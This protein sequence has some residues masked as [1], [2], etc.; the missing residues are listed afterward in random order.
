MDRKSR[1]QK[2]FFKLLATEGTGSDA[3][4]KGKIYVVHRSTDKALL[5]SSIVNNE[6]RLGSV[7]YK[8][9]GEDTILEEYKDYLENYDIRP[10]LGWT[11]DDTLNY[12]SYQFEKTAIKFYFSKDLVE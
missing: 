6:K 2:N 4:P 12:H 9:Q 3:K 1:R 11:G 5:A 7:G 8:S 10:D